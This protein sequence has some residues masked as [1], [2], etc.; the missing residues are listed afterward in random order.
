M[1]R[2]GSGLHHKHIE[3]E[4]MAEHELYLAWLGQAS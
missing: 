2:K 4:M 3:F 1:L